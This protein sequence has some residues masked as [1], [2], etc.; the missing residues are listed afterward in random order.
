MEIAGLLFDV[1]GKLRLLDYPDVNVVAL[2]RELTK[3]EIE[4]EV[5]QAV[6]LA[7]MGVVTYS[8]AINEGEKAVTKAVRNVGG[9]EVVMMLDGFPK[10]GTEHARFYHPDG[11]YHHAS[12]EGRLLLLAVYPE[13]YENPKLIELTEEE[14]KRKVV[15]KGLTYHP[16]PHDSKRWRMIAGNMMLQMVAQEPR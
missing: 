6:K 1:M 16:I 4:A 11:A 5:E 9:C 13:N 8:A 12:G 7:K 2:K 14:L 10:E 3:E 15:E